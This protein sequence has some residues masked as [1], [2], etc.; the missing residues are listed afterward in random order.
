M[1]GNSLMNKMANLELLVKEKERLKKELTSR[2]LALSFL[3]EDCSHDIIIYCGTNN[4][5]LEKQKIIS[6]FLYC[7]LCGLKNFK[8]TLDPNGQIIL[9]D[10]L[11]SFGDPLQKLSEMTQIIKMCLQSYGNKELPYILEKMEQCYHLKYYRVKL[12]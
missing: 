11:F 3:P 12:L 9:F 8:L 5:C 6:A 7:P 10:K 1:T 4:L 2:E